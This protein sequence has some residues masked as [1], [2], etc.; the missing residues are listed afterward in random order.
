MLVHVI[1][2]H[3]KNRAVVAFHLPIGLG[4][5]V[6]VKS[7][8]IPKILQT[9]WKN[10][11]ANC[12]PL[13]EIKHSGGPYLKTQCSTK[14]TATLYVVILRQGI[15]WVS[16]VNWSVMTN[17]KRYPFLVLCNGPRISMQSDASGLVAGNNLRKFVRLRSLSLFF[18]QVEHL[19]TVA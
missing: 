9:T 15:T 1:T 17:K 19:R 6:L 18:A 16:L 7:F 13:S 2:K 11:A 8:K 10:L 3:C 14:A 12:L 4:G 5:Y